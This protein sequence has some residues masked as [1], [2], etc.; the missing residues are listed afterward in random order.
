MAA[1][2]IVSVNLSILSDSWSDDGVGNTYGGI[3]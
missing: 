1:T 3:I 2:T